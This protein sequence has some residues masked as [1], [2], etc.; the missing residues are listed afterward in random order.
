MAVETQAPDVADVGGPPAR[1]SR[2]SVERSAAAFL[3]PLALVLIAGGL[4]FYRVGYPDRIYFDETYYALHAEEIIDVGVEKGFAV[5]PPVGK[6]LIA[7][8]KSFVA[9]PVVNRVAK[10]D[11]V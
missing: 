9:N 4:R 11:V 5:H 3:I 8:S 7:S 10:Y 6:W 1:P 2:R